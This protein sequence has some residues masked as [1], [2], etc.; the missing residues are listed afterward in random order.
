M[1]APAPAGGLLYYGGPVLS[2]V[3]VYAVF[4][5]NQVDQE[6]QSQIGGFFS[7]VSNSSYLDW[8]EEY[9]TL[10]TAVDGRKGT[11]QH[12]NR[13]SYAGA[14]TINPSN[15][16]TNLSDTDVQ[17]ELQKQIT[18]GVLPKPDENTLYMT[19]FPPGVSISAFGATSCV[20]FCAYHSFKG[21]V[22]TDHFFYGVMPDIGGAC[23]SGC[24]FGGTSFDSLTAISS[25][26]FME[27]ITDP[28]P[29]PGNTPAYPQAWNTSDGSEIGDLCAGTN[30]TLTAANKTYTVQSE[31][32]NKT[33]ACTTTPW[34][35]P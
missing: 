26:E 17:N 19:Y 1:V 21:D 4:W 10:I 13:G 2:Q 12:L 27:S 32:D 7:T 9:N 29:T 34:T 5:G 30:N 20:E 23:A 33:G 24:G 31:F 14:I 16:S 11:Q 22:T 8:I 6:T 28:F 35:S 15:V 3:K 25:H 18:A